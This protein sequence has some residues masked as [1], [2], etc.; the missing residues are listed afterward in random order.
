MRVDCVF[1]IGK[2]CG[3]G[4]REG[5]LRKPR[6]RAYKGKTCLIRQGIDGDSVREQLQKKVEEFGLRVKD[7]TIRYK[8][9][10]FYCEKLPGADTILP[11]YLELLGISFKKEI[12]LTFSLPLS[13]AHR[14]LNSKPLC[15]GL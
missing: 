12:G 11:P 2:V 7:S 4:T 15:H 13:K 8:E 10:E 1:N 6:C 9:A 5:L 14:F 3:S